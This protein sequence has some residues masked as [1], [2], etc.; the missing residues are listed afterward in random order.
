MYTSNGQQYNI[1]QPGNSPNFSAPQ[2]T[3]GHMQVR[4]R[5]GNRN[6][7]SWLLVQSR[8][9][10]PHVLRVMMGWT[11]S[12]AYLQRDSTACTGWEGNAYVAH[13]W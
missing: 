7:E 5:A 10:T 1:L 6:Q 8:G 11:V 2:F 4:G 13:G 3:Q 9:W 12:I